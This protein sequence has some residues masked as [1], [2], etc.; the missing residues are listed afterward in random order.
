MLR[1][2]PALRE[3]FPA[4]LQAFD[5]LTAAEAVELLDRAPSPTTAARRSRSKIAAAL[6]CAHR[7]DVDARAA[8][9]QELLRAPALRQPAVVENAYA[10]VVTTQ[11]RLIA[12]LSTQIDALAEQVDDHFGRHPDAEIYLSQPG[13][14]A[15]LGTRV[16]AEFG[17]D[18]HRYIDAKARKNYAGTSPITKA[19]GYK[20]VVLARNTR[21]SAAQH[22]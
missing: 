19:S 1:L 4:A 14:G 7:L 18:A 21:L 16:L 15:V 17:D 11:V 9:I 10:A 20:H 12:E 6:G 2:R 3:F 8:K 13:I 22:Q 5:D